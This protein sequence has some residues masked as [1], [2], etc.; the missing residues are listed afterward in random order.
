MGLGGDLVGPAD[1]RPRSLRVAPAVAGAIE[2]A[3]LIRAERDAAVLDE[4]AAM[5]RRP[6]WPGC[7]M[8]EW[9][10]EEVAK[11]R[12]VVNGVTDEGEV[13]GGAR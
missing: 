7:E 12:D 3:A 11:V 8:L 5:L 10:A 2:R 13:I 6:E 9:I 4:V 1:R